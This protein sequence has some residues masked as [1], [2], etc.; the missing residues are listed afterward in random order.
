MSAGGE[1]GA[2]PESKDMLASKRGEL[3]SD[4]AARRVVDKLALK[5]VETGRRPHEALSRRRQ[6]GRAAHPPGKV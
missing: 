1:V 6:R 5:A 2:G 3:E 4:E